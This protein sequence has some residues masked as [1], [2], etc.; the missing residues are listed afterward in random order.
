[1]RVGATESNRCSGA[2]V[3]KRA[4]RLR[5]RGTAE[6]AVATWIFCLASYF[7]TISYIATCVTLV[8]ILTSVNLPQ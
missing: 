1:M 8:T 4:A 5:R 7:S 2:G 6:A 3:G